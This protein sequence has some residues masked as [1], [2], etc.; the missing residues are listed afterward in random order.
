MENISFNTFLKPFQN[1]DELFYT[2]YLLVEFQHLDVDSLCLVL[3]KLTNRLFLKS[4]I[5]S[6]S[7]KF[8]MFSAQ[9]GTN[10]FSKIHDLPEMINDILKRESKCLKF[11][12]PAESCSFCS[13]KSMD[14]LNTEEAISYFVSHK[15]LK[16]SISS[17]KCLACGANH[18][19]S[20]AEKD[21]SRKSLENFTDKKFIAFSRET[22]LETKIL[23]MFTSDLIFK[24]S[25]FQGFC[26]AFNHL[27]SFANYLFQRIPDR[28]YLEEKRL[29]EN[30]FFYKAMKFSEEY[31][32]GLSGLPFPYLNELDQYLR[33]LKPYL[34]PY[35]CKKWSG[36]YHKSLCCHQNCS[37]TINLLKC[38]RLKCMFDDVFIKVDEI[39]QK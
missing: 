2:I 35:F 29:V 37:L 26:S 6:F 24:H 33:C 20:Y 8:K 30:W 18:Y 34:F 11:V 14:K 13:S 32:F 25:T 27:S 39:G 28:I 17:K 21:Q 3:E 12:S 38:N 1:V 16:A 15:P 19:L 10:F 31:F 5:E 4:D 22:I 36:I 9:Y 23:Q 7:R